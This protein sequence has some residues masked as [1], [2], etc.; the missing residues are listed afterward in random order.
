MVRALR[1]I[2]LNHSLDVPAGRKQGDVTEGKKK[3]RERTGRLL[4]LCAVINL[5][6]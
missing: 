4:N 2:D 3:K 6:D 1:D 5:S